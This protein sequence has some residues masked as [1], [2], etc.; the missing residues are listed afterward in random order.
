MSN[1]CVL[2]K[3]RKVGFHWG[4][5]GDVSKVAKKFV[6]D[7]NAV[8]D[9]S[10]AIHAIV[11]NMTIEEL[12]E[13]LVILN[14]EKTC[15]YTGMDEMKRKI[16][17]TLH[18]DAHEKNDSLRKF[19]HWN[20]NGFEV[21]SGFYAESI[22]LKDSVFKKQGADTFQKVISRIIS[23][24]GNKYYSD[25]SKH[26]EKWIGA[27]HFQ[28]LRLQDLEF[29]IS[30]AKNLAEQMETLR[31][32]LM[33]SVEVLESIL[34]VNESVAD[35]DGKRMLWVVRQGTPMFTDMNETA[36]RTFVTP[37]KVSKRAKQSDESSIGRMLLTDNSDRI[38]TYKEVESVNPARIEEVR[39]DDVT[40][41]QGVSEDIVGVVGEPAQRTKPD[42]PVFTG[43]SSLPEMSAPEVRVVR[44]STQ[45]SERNDT[46]V[47]TNK[48]KDAKNYCHVIFGK[49]SD[50][51]I[52]LE[53]ETFQKS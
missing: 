14:D 40:K 47:T 24:S 12:K 29:F 34:K 43:I 22:H 20:R 26:F 2:D 33:D 21:L 38:G 6:K 9:R 13:Q 44:E 11:D 31:Q 19:V 30:S 17:S 37:E 8:Q 45:E 32:S 42:K 3:T 15:L 27:N 49:L 50:N 25:N 1:R 41:L 53:N 23:N 28:M 36:K 35:Y 4:K 51:S 48:G 18:V 39:A 46:D 16:L 7:P 5:L 10:V 52:S